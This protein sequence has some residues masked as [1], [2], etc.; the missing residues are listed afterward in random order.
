MAAIQLRVPLTNVMTVTDRLFSS[1]E[2]D[3]SEVRKQTSQINQNLYRLLRIISNMSDAYSH[4]STGSAGMQTA[5]LSAV[6]AE[7]IEKA[8]AVFTD[9]NIRLQYSGLNAP[10]YGLADTEKLERAIYNLLSN[11]VKFS[12]AGSTVNAVLARNGNQ[13]SFT[14]CNTTAE[15]LTEFSLWQRYRREPAIEDPRHGLGLGMTLISAV[16]SLHGGTVLVDHPTAGETRVT[17]TIPI[18]KETSG[19]LRSPVL[20]ISDYAGGRDTGLLE[21]SEILSADVYEK[22]N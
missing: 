20:R 3:D 13:L 16:A 17:M 10:V 1:L 14:V 12:Q 7:I 6:I 11:A 8:Q 4:L 2:S 9:T 21:L 22:I 19:N 18:V 5:D 15:D